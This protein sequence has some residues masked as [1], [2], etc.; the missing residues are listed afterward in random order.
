MVRSSTHTTCFLL[1]SSLGLLV[2]DGCAH[3]RVQ[4]RWTS[5]PPVVDGE[6]GDWAD[7]IEYYVFDEERISLSVRNDADALYLMFFTRDPALTRVLQFAGVTIWIDPE[8]GKNQDLSIHFKG[9]GRDLGYPEDRF[10]GEQPV[11]AAASQAGVFGHEVRLPPAVFGQDVQNE[12]DGS[13]AALTVGIHLAGLSP[14][15]IAEIQQRS[16]GGRPPHA[17]MGPPPG[18][19]MGRGGAAGAGQGSPRRGPPPGVRGRGAPGSG[20]RPSQEKGRDGGEDDQREWNGRGCPQ[21]AVPD[22]PREHDLW[23]TIA[24]GTPES[25]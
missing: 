9:D 13:P 8:G 6:I 23:L 4:S 18:V 25:S 3:S 2:L 5:S 24:L 16:G 10:D 1:A 19:G 11:I 17:G 22:L 14:E 15:L 20:E 21:G 7:P 12:E